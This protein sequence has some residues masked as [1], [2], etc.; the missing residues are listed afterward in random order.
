MLGCIFL[1]NKTICICDSIINK[2]RDY[3]TLFVNLF[4]ITQVALLT[5]QLATTAEEWKFA[6]FSDIA[7]QPNSWDC[8][9]FVYFYTKSIIAKQSLKRCDCKIER[10]LVKNVLGMSYQAPKLPRIDLKAL[11]FTQRQYNEI[12]KPPKP[13]TIVF[14]FGAGCDDFFSKIIFPCTKPS[15]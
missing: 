11:G 2:Q 4:K 12:I 7:Q 5:N 15:A 14:Y 8:G 9:V 6:L 3:R 13:Q 10:N 1:D